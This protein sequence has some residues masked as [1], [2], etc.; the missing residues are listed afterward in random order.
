MKK[1]LIML[2][3]FLLTLTVTAVKADTESPGGAGGPCEQPWNNI[4]YI[5]RVTIA[6]QTQE[7]PVK[8]TYTYRN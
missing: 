6:N 4:C 7:I 1:K 8:G 2:C 3:V 5:L